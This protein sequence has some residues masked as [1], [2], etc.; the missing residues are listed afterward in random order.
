MS[1]AILAPLPA[2]AAGVGVA[3]RLSGRRPAEGSRQRATRHA[4]HG[5]ILFI[6]FGQRLAVPL[7]TDSMSFV[8][9]VS[10]VALVTMWRV[11]TVTLDRRRTSLY[12][13]AAAACAATSLIAALGT[14][15]SIPSLLLLVLIWFPWCFRLALPDK[16][17][18]RLLDSSL[19]CF[20]SAMRVVAWLAISQVAL[21]LAGIQYVDLLARALPRQLL[22]TG[23]NTSYPLTYGSP[24]HKANAWLLLEPS[25]LSQFLALA[26]LIGM[27]RAV[28]LRTQVLFLVA[29]GAAYSGTGILLLVVGSLLLLVRQPQKVRRGVVVLVLGMAGVILLSPLRQGL[30]GRLGEFSQ[31][32]TSGSSRFIEPYQLVYNYLATPSHILWGGGPAA[33]RT[34]LPPHSANAIFPILSKLL[35]EYGLLAGSLF[36]FF[37]IYAV[38][39]RVQQPVLPGIALMLLFV[40][41]AS[42]QQPSTVMLAWLLTG[43]FAVSDRKPSP[44]VN[45]VMKSCHERLAVREDSS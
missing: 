42:L 20:L 36:L 35:A 40:L 2:S 28:R 8:L 19:D 9:P 12:F 5:L 32:G 25:F 29:L 4:V 27:V 43:L 41:S 30:F 10:Y 14:A 7:G 23:Y 15:V 26:V 13:A 6:V 1:A 38:C 34:S 3:G 18:L 45:P 33:T 44:S 22:D 16:A 24:L 39:A 11:G 31:S 21:Q 37:I 17:R